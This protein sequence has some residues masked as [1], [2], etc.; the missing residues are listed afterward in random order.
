ML[1]ALAR[2][3]R[4]HSSPEMARAL[5]RVQAGVLRAVGAPAGAAPVVFVQAG[6]GT[7]AMEMA[8]ANL[9][10]PGQPLVVV[11]HGAFGERYANLARA[12]GALVEELNAEWGERVEADRLRSALR[13]TGAR[14]VTATHVDTSTGVAADLAAYAEVVRESG[15]LLV[16]DAVASLGGMPVQMEQLGVDVVVGASQ[17]ALAAPPGL[18]IVVA[19]QRALQHRVEQ[20]TSGGYFFDWPN[21]LNA[22][23]DPTRGYFATLPTNLLVAAAVAVELAEAEGWEERFQ[24]H[25]RGA[26]AWRQACVALGLTVVGR[27]GQLGCTVSAMRLPAG[28]ESAPLLAAVAER[29]VLLGGGLGATRSSWLRAGHMG[30]VGLAELRLGVEALESGLRRLG[31]GVGPGVETLERGWAEQAA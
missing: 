23:E 2:P 1:A 20:G 3:T 14:V 19:S 8:V 7:S 4:S 5:A 15:A 12:R 18:A 28:L 11:S 21:W 26:R 10:L 16:L 13:R 24:R 25:R 6:S 27:P 17:K 22:M 30:A 9:V 29:G 31:L